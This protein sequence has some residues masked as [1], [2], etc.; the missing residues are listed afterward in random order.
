MKEASRRAAAALFRRLGEQATATVVA[1]AP[2][3]SLERALAREL[4]LCLG[5][6]P[7][8]VRFFRSGRSALAGLMRALAGKHPGGTVLVPAYICNVVPDAVRAVGLV[9]EPVPAGETLLPDL[10]VVGHRIADP[11]VVGVVF[12]SVFGAAGCTRAALEGIRASRPDLL[13]VLDE[14][15]NL[16][17][18]SPAEIDGR[19][20][21]ILSFNQKNVLGAMG[22]AVLMW[23]NEVSVHVDP[24]SWRHRLE[25]ELRMWAVHAGQMW[26][27]LRDLVRVLR[28]A[29]R[30]STPPRLEYSRCRGH[31]G[32]EPR[33]IRRI[34]LARALL[35]VRRLAEVE[36]AR[37]RN[38]QEVLLALSQA[39]VRAVPTTERERSPF[40]PFL[41]TGSRPPVLPGMQIKGPYACDA[42]ATASIRPDLYCVVN[43]GVGVGG[44]G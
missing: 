38:A 21:M 41:V 29:L 15:Q 10:E 42:S 13:V 3:A 1:F 4:H 9:A 23:G 39:G 26:R 28:G 5:K 24:G 43:D 44:A 37:R 7:F 31:Y 12:A 14:C 18:P 25:D 36:Q 2:R 40:I 35:G 30:A 32:L 20:A 11:N 8:V 22:G 34:S 6:G 16:V 33:P 19:S 27:T 17:C